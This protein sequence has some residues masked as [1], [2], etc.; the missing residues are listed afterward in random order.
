MVL[1]HFLFIYVCLCMCLSTYSEKY[2]AVW[3][4]KMQFD[5]HTSQQLMVFKI[6]SISDI[7]LLLPQEASWD[8][9]ASGRT[10]LKTINELNGEIKPRPEKIRLRWAGRSTAREARG[11]STRARNKLQLSWVQGAEFRRNTLVHATH[12]P[13]CI[14]LLRS[15]IPINPT[16]LNSSPPLILS[17]LGQ[18]F[19]EFSKS[20]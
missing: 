19:S 7:F 18:D 17:D 4:K 3:V 20:I 16:F 13:L 15:Y 6:R 14:Q 10:W 12:A 5:L 9:A 11:V 1:F 2:Y 8:E